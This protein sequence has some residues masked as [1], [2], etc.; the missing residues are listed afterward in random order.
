MTGDLNAMA[1]W[2]LTCG[3][4]TVALKSTGVYWTLVCD[5]LEQRG[6]KVS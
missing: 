1:D 4:D 6:L 5:V 3:V 2:L